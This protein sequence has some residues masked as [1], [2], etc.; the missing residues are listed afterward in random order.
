MNYDDF[1][2]WTLV[3][4][5]F[6]ISSHPFFHA[7][8]LTI[9]FREQQTPKA[10]S[11]LYQEPWCFFTGP[12]LTWINFY[13][14]GK[15]LGWSFATLSVLP[16]MIRLDA[17]MTDSVRGSSD[18][19]LEQRLVIEPMIRLPHWFVLTGVSCNIYVVVQFYPWFKFSFLLFLGMIMY[20]NEFETKENKI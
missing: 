11:Q 17:L 3:N 14:L 18:S 13:V 2:F 9:K 20:D 8:S 1:H 16:V 6:Q 10:L 5:T 15:V 19:L 7:C 4:T 12:E